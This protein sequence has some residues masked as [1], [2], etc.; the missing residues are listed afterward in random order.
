VSR[1]GLVAEFTIRLFYNSDNNILSIELEI[2]E[3]SILPVGTIHI[4]GG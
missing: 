3:T 1:F 2:S 4:T